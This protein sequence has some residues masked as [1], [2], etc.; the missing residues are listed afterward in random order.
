MGDIDSETRTPEAPRRVRARCEGR[1]V[2]RMRPLGPV[3]L[4][5]GAPKRGSFR[6]CARTSLGKLVGNRLTD[7]KIADRRFD[8]L[9]G[10]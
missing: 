2:L 6:T 8:R 4:A 7:R 5:L 9:I 1:N 10:N 3:F